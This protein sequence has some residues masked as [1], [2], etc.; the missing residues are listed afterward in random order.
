[1]SEVVPGVASIL[2]EDSEGYVHEVTGAWMYGDQLRI[3]ID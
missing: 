2:V 3:M 1:M